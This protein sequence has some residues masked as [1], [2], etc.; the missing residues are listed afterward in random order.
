VQDVDPD[1]ALGE[2][3]ERVHDGLQ[4]TLDVGLDD[5]VQHR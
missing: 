4:R 1:L 2:L 5:E 3:A